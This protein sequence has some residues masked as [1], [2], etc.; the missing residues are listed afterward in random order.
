MHAGCNL[1]WLHFG[2]QAAS[3]NWVWCAKLQQTMKVWR[4]AACWWN[5]VYSS[6]CSKKIAFCFRRTKSMCCG[7]LFRWYPGI[8]LGWTAR[9]VQIQLNKNSC[10]STSR[11]NAPKTPKKN[12]KLQN[13][14]SDNTKRWHALV[15][16]TRKLFTFANVSLLYMRVFCP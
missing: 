1:G 4:V 10:R 5:H 14:Q 13:M 2:Y 3:L 11:R 16:V 8:P 15:K 12:R 9:N 7:S 6:P